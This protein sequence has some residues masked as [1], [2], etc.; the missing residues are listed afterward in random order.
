[1][2]RV[3][4]QKCNTVLKNITSH[5][6]VKDLFPGGAVRSGAL[7][8]AHAE[9]GVPGGEATREEALNRLWREVQHSY[10]LEGVQAPD[11]DIRTYDRLREKLFND[12]L[13]AIV[14]YRKGPR[15]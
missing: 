5:I 15:P 10:V 11:F 1:M 9:H 7:G 8:R 6:I 13:N 14:P 12:V 3:A 2:K 4:V